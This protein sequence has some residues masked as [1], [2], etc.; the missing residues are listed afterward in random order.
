MKTTEGVGGQK[1]PAR[2]WHANGGEF[3]DVG[4][5]E[6]RVGSWRRW[7]ATPRVAPAK[8]LAWSLPEVADLVLHRL[9]LPATPPLASD[10]WH[11]DTI[12]QRDT[13]SE[14]NSVLEGMRVHQ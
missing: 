8:Q 1:R 6:E 12:T 13:L 3:H 10:H 7:R 9:A 4:A 2:G 5:I 11:A 14:I